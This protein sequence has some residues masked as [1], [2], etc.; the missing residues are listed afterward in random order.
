MNRYVF[1]DGE[2][3]DLSNVVAAMQRAGFEVR[4]VESLREHYSQTLHAWVR[5]LEGSWEEA[6][7]RSLI[8]DGEQETYYAKFNEGALLR[9][10]LKDQA[11]FFKAALGPNQG[12]RTPNEVRSAFDLNPKTGEETGPDAIPK[13]AAAKPAKEPVDE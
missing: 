7:A 3:V 13:P 1:P 12:Y 8:S 5:N 6:V 9:G 10:S 4:D 11:E 2:L